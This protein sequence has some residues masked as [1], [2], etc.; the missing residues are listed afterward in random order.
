MGGF[1]W[2]ERLWWKTAGQKPGKGSGGPGSLAERCLLV[3]PGNCRSLSKD[4]SHDKVSELWVAS[5]SG[6]GPQR[7][8]ILFACAE[9]RTVFLEADEA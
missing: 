5:R 1:G 7:T 2:T 8:Q 9:N 3:E 4:S 6:I